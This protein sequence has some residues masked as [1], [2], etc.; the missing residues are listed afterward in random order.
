VFYQFWLNT[1]D[2]S[3]VDYLKLF[4]FLPI[5]EINEIKIEFQT[6]PGSRSAQKKLAAEVTTLVH[7]K[8]SAESAIKVSD[9]LFANGDASVLHSEEK[10]ILLQNAPTYEIISDV[11]ITDV[12]VNSGLASSK[13][14]ARTFIESG[15]VTLGTEKIELSEFQ[16]E[17]SSGGLIPLRRGKKNFVILF[18]K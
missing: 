13:R 15:A 10:E 14:E 7:G 17:L 18:K 1:S 2:E 5:E 9:I 12:L 6:S 16:I 11:T 4:T 3:V 8:D